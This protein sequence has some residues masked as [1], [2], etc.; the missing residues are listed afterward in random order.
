LCFIAGNAGTEQRTCM[1]TSEFHPVSARSEKS[2]RQAQRKT[3]AVRDQLK[4]AG[5]ELHLT[6]SVIE[7]G[8]PKGAAPRDVAHALSQQDEIEEKV[9]EAADEL[10]EVH[11]L[12]EEEAAERERLEQELAQA[13][14]RPSGRGK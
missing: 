5:G 7:Q 4:V 6:K 2:L 1:R 13:L 9:L 14:S 12:L 3:N 8:L 11:G 10:R